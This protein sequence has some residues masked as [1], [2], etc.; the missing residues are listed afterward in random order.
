MRNVEQALAAPE[1]E[2]RP[3]NYWGWLENITPEETRWQIDRMAEAGLG[4]YDAHARGGQTMPYAGQQWM[5]SVRAMIEA[6]TP[7]PRTAMFFMEISSF[8]C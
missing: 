2:Y 7:Q 1:M 4:G 5:D 8:V 6:I 3:R